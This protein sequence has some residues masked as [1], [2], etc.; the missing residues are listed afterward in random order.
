M[1]E[2][3]ILKKD[4]LG[5]DRSQFDIDEELRSYLKQT[6]WYV[7]RELETGK[8]VPEGIKQN[9]ELARA[10]IKISLL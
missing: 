5:G 7:I 9:R 8:K 6:D 10:E 3:L 2:Q 4:E 1:I